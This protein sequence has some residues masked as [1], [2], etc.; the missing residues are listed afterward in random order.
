MEPTML[1][2]YRAIMDPNAN[3]LRTI[4]PVQR[5][6]TMLYL[7]I[8]WTAIFCAA[9]GAWFWYGAIVVVHLLIALGFLLTGLTFYTAGRV[10]DGSHDSGHRARSGAAV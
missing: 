5:F 6:Q 2:V 9:T 4:P 3:P 1:S 7:S 8:M 10:A